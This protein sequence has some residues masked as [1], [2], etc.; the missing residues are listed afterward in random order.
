MSLKIVKG[1]LFTLAASQ[2][3]DVV[4]NGLNCFCTAPYAG[5]AADFEKHFNIS[6]CSYEQE[7]YKGKYNKLGN[8][9]SKIAYVYDNKFHLLDNGRTDFEDF[10]LAESKK[11]LVVNAYTQYKPGANGD[12]VALA[13]CLK[14]L[15]VYAKGLNVLLPLIGGGI[16]KLKPENI[17]ILMEKTLVDCNATLVLL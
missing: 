11:I 13:I 14:K 10:S 9:E 8:L 5:I 6:T 3:Y 2:H 12:M 17:K 4:V 1:D 16:A 7:K 15:N